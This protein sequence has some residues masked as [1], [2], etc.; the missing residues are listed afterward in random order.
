[1]RNVADIVQCGVW[2]VNGEGTLTDFKY[3]DN[4]D[5]TIQ[6]NVVTTGQW[7]LCAY[8][9]GWM[10][11]DLHLFRFIHFS[12]KYLFMIQNYYF[13]RRTNWMW[14]FKY[15]YEPFPFESFMHEIPQYRGN[16]IWICQ[17]SKWINKSWTN[18]ILSFPSE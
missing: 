2:S 3:C 10:T 13:I 17:L 1:M 8:M 5:T 16:R 14:L 7:S 11:A 9:N 6:T 18:K 4:F 12:V 15:T